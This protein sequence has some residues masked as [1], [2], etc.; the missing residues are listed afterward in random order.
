MSGPVL[1]KWTV[2]GNNL[3]F[4]DALTG[5]SPA[6]MPDEDALFALAMNELERTGF[7][8]LIVLQPGGDEELAAVGRRNGRDFVSP[9]GDID[10][11]IRILE[12]DGSESLSCGN[13]LLCAAAT[14]RRNGVSLPSTILTGLASDEP[15]PV[16]IGTDG[17]G[18]PW[19]CHEHAR[20]VPD[21]LYQP[22]EGRAP[23]VAA[24]CP[25]DVL[26]DLGAGVAGIP[27]GLSGRLVLTGEPHL[28]IFADKAGGWPAV[29]DGEG[30]SWLSALGEHLNQDRR[31]V[32]PDGVNVIA[33]EDGGV[34]IGV[35]Y[36]SY[37][38]G[39]N[40]ET[41]ACGTGAMAV[42]S[43]WRALHTN[44]AAELV[45]VRPAGAPSDGYSVGFRANAMR[46]SGRAVPLDGGSASEKGVAFSLPG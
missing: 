4:L 42:A 30:R 18:R 44:G 10:A 24:G 22:E 35:R 40:Q 15:W 14:M 16:R 7:D 2:F 20:L 32:F 38:R 3:L 41:G 33:A 23:V 39:V 25:M 21:A 36:R 17:A 9:G 1:R 45:R 8:S 26:H 13:G 37:E 29:A 31:D 34:T 46:L 43:V 12:P 11:I 6:A 5:S 27:E 28:V 19:L